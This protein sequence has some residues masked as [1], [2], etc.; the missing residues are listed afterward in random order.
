MPDFASMTQLEAAA[1]RAIATTAGAKLNPKAIRTKGSLANISFAM[2]AA[3]AQENERRVLAK[4]AALTYS[5]A[6]GAELDALVAERTFRIVSRKGAAPAR[7]PVTIRRPAGGALLAQ[8]I[9]A[10]ELVGDVEGGSSGVTFALDYSVPFAAGATGPIETT[11]TATAAGSATNVPASAVARFVSPSSFTD[12]TFAVSAVSDPAGGADVERDAELLERAQRFPSAVRRGTLAAVEF[13]ALT[14]KGVRQAVAEEVLDLAGEPTGMIFLYLADINGDCNS[15]L[16]DEVRLALREWR[17]GGIPVRLFGSVPTFV[18][19]VLSIGALAG[20]STSD[21]QTLARA[22]VIAAA[23]RVPTNGT[24]RRSAL[25]AALE[26]VA[27]A[28]V[29]A[30]SIVEPALDVVPARGQTLRTRA[31][32][33]SFV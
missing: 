12:T 16:M 26:A 10:G 22:S 20:H 4:L 5:G 8:T 6:K 24:L 15:A 19:I 1:Y 9:N 13:G 2:S 23:A 30:S 3:I 11:A 32:L 14:V 17:A 33:V 31:D 18:P 21:V 27:G 7:V 25:F 29:T 28:E